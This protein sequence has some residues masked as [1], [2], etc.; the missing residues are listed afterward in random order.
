MYLTKLRLAG[1]ALAALLFIGGVSGAAARDCPNRGAI[2]VSRVIEV[3]TSSGPLFGSV[4]YKVE[5]ILQPGEVVLTFDDGPMRAYTRAVLAALE[6][7][8]TK[9]MFFMVG[10]MAVSDPE[11]VREV[12]RKGHTIAAHTWSHKNQ[13]ALSANAARLEIELGFSAIAKAA[14]QP[15]APFFRFP[16]LSDPKAS[17]EYLRRRQV[18]IFSID[19]DAVDFR[20]RNPADVH[21]RIMN[22]LEQR[23]RGIL[24][25]HDIQPSTVG[26]IGGLLDAMKAKGYRV[27]HVVAKAPVATLAEADALAEAE[28]Q[29]KRLAATGKPLA[30]RALVWQSGRTDAAPPPPVK[31]AA[32][33]PKPQ[34]RP[35]REVR[36][37]APPQAPRRPVQAENSEPKT[38]TSLWQQRISASP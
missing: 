32:P 19:I 37:P 38:A 5:D 11:M 27:V 25:F 13:A 31:A 21:R 12:A 36:A 29:K 4:Q 22:G 20:T 15:I 14:E 1:S 24:L 10:R 3:D 8:C 2:G 18:A 16:Y 17:I 26:A 35:R 23:G 7:H 6:A 30:P 28:H 34:A 9:G 33:A